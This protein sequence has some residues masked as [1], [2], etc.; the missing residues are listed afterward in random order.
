[1][2]TKSSARLLRCRQERPSSADR[3][4]IC[5]LPLSVP[6]L[7]LSSSLSLLERFVAVHFCK[8]ASESDRSFD[9][10]GDRRLAIGFSG[11]RSGNTIRRLQTRP[12]PIKS[13]TNLFLLFLI[14]SNL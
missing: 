13:T 5:F 4:L 6:G 3:Q 9:S 8:M 7:S 11:T 1:M 14:S 12:D 10:G 2:I